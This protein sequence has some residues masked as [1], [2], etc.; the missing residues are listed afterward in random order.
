M[1]INNNRQSDKNDGT[2]EGDDDGREWRMTG[3][4]AKH[5]KKGNEGRPKCMMNG[6]LGNK[7]KGR[8]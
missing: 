6:E 8:A 2:L 4:P 7:A 3:N 1:D 5:R